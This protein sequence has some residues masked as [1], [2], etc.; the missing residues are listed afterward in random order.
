MLAM[1]SILNYYDRKRVGATGNV[2]EVARCQLRRPDTPTTAVTADYLMEATGAEHPFARK[3]FD[4]WL[5]AVGD[6]RQYHILD[7]FHWE[8]KDGSWLA[9]KF[10]EFDTAWIDIFSPYNNRRLLID[11]LAVEECYR[12]APSFELI[13]A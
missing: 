5:A 1:Y 7:I 12:R 10:L 9:Q 2:S 6:C 13:H 4:K 3:H 11:M 8:Q